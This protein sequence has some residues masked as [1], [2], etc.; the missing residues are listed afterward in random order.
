MTNKIIALEKQHEKDLR[1][2]LFLKKKYAE[3]VVKVGR[4][5]GETEENVSRAAEM[6]AR[7]SSGTTARSSSSSSS[8]HTPVLFSS[9]SLDTRNDPEQCTTQ[10]RKPLTVAGAEPLVRRR[11]TTETHK[12]RIAGGAEARDCNISDTS[13]QRG[14]K[15]GIH[16]VTLPSS[17][18]KKT[19]P[20][21]T[22]KIIPQKKS[23]YVEVVRK[24]SDRENLPGHE[25]DECYKY[26]AALEQQG[27]C[28]PSS[29]AEMLQKCSRH[30]SRCTPPS[31][32]D[33]FWDLSI[34]DPASWTK[35]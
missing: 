6:D 12:T 30:K 28:S 15:R 14:N 8:A 25:C 5:F 21:H 16:E 20:A 19:I 31:T 32:P 35:G 9:A 3:L 29:K 22:C 10:H 24:K 23:K 13:P 4:K 7:V 26:F 18:A 27:I 1:T 2:E 33:G 17:S 11:A 34:K